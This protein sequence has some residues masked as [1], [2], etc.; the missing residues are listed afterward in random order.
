MN[1]IKYKILVTL[2][3]PYKSLTKSEL[4]NTI[5]YSA[6][7]D[8]NI[9][10]DN[11]N[12]LIGQKLVENTR[13]SSDIIMVTSKGRDFIS[14]YEAHIKSRNEM[15]DNVAKSISDTSS[16]ADSVSNAK[17]HDFNWTKAGCISAAIIGL[18]GIA[19]TLLVHWGLM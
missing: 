4:L 9:L 15:I 5:R 13:P 19:V 16:K 6:N 1:A 7:I 17:D 8:I 2:N 11:F 3:D 12:D 10:N 18:L 14:D